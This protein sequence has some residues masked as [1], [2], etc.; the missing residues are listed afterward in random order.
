MEFGRP[1]YASREMIEQYKG[2]DKRK[3]VSAFLKEIEE[4]LREILFSAPSYGELQAIYMAR[5]LYLPKKTPHFT[6]EQEN[7]LYHRF[8]KGYNAFKDH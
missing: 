4:R 2:S 8:F 5:K 3:A 7:D 1:Y 6:K